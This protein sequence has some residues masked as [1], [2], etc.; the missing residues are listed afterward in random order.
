[1]CGIER[2]AAFYRGYLIDD[3]SLA[4][5]TVALATSVAL[6]SLVYLVGCFAPLAKQPTGETVAQWSDLAARPTTP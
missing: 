1:M 2:H 4:P 3:Q 5:L 6:W